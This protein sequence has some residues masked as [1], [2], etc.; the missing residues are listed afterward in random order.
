MMARSVFF[1]PIYSSSGAPLCQ[2]PA[3]LQE[4]ADEHANINWTEAC[5]NLE[6]LP[7]LQE[8]GAHFATQYKKDV[9][10][11]LS[12]VQHHVHKKDKDGNYV[13][14]HS[15][16]RKA[17]KGRKKVIQCKADFPKTKIRTTSTVL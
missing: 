15:C 4:D 1:F 12:R 17:A 7:K 9:Q 11:V 13:P 2:T 8:D 3:F 16:Q 6:L 5:T 10:F 14:L